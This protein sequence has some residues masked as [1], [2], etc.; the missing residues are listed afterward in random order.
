MERS[1]SILFLTAV[2]GAACIGCAA[3]VQPELKSA[4]S[5]QVDVDF[6]N[7]VL[8]AKHGAPVLYP[9][10]RPHCPYYN[11]RQ[12]AWSGVSPAYSTSKDVAIAPA[13]A[14]SGKP[15]DPSRSDVVE[16]SEELP[17]MNSPG[18]ANS[19]R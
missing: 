18:A 15:S 17:P 3:P 11:Y 2:A 6:E 9:F 1:A 8:L 4:R 13:E 5:Y 7:I 10:S 14:V 16:P 19:G 12:R